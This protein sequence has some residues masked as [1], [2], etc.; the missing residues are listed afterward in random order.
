LTVNQAVFLVL[1]LVAALAA[2]G[3]VGFG[4]N[5]VRAA[6]MLVLNFF[7]LGLVYFA[8]GAQLLGITQIMVY[9]GAIMVLFL[10]VVMMLQLHHQGKVVPGPD[11]RAVFAWVLGLA[12]GAMVFASVIVPLMS[13]TGSP[14]GD[15]YGAPQ[16]VGR[17]LFTTYVLPFEVA[18][19]LLLIGIVGSILLAKRRL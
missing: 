6:L 19:V 12:L 7:V 2:V 18:S 11:G 8:L 15:G 13:V 16:S 14:I 17:V 5:P 1:A 10:F 3:V 9:A 4:N